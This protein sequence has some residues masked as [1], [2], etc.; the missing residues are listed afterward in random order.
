MNELSF[1]TKA[2]HAGYDYGE[3]HSIF[4]PI[5]MGVAFPFSSGEEASRICT[6]QQAGYVYART[7]NHTNAVFEKRLAALEGAEECLGTSSGLAAIFIGVLGLLEQPGRNFLWSGRLYGNTQN[8]FRRSLPLLGIEA[9]CVKEPD[10][11]EAWDALIDDKTKF[12]FFE[13]PSNPDVFVADVRGLVAL[14]KGRGLKVMVDSTLATPAVLRPLE[15]GA[16]VVIHST[17]K[18]LSGHSAA[19][20]GALVST[21]EFIDGVR[22]SHHHYI[23]PSMN[24]FAAWLTLIGMETL[25]VRMPRMINSAQ[26]I[27]EFL[28]SHPKV[29]SVN[30]PGLKSHP[31]HHLAME[32]MGSGGTSLLAFVVRGGMKTAWAVLERLRIPCHATHL[33]GNQSIAVHPATTTHGKLTPEERATSNVPDGLIRFSVGLEEPEDLIADLDQA[34]EVI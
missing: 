26:R 18:C 9:R 20:G 27:A 28:E 10:K 31:Q 11:L 33:G 25:H 23:G 22:T 30:Y 1:A 17:T 16:D 7:R 5:D 24:A 13:S 19:L 8:Q 34:L 4:P 32:Q 12:L 15:M 21:K 6:G 29:E 3:G 2:L 14:A